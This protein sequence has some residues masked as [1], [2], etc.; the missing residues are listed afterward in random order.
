MAAGDLAAFQ[1]AILG[2]YDAHGRHLAFRGTRD[3]YAVLVSEAMAQQ[4]QISRVEPAWRAFM[5]RFP[6]VEALA[7][8]STAEVLR[9][10]T[11]L[12]YNRRAVNL[13][14]A[15]REAVASYGGQLPGDVAA[16]LAL[17]GVG[18]YTARAVA[19]IAFDLPVGA[20]DTN[21]RRVLGR[22]SAGAGAAP[23]PAE[24]QVLADASVPADRPADWTHAVMDVG[25]RFC[26]P[27]PAC[28]ACP[29]RPWCRYAA[30]A[31]TSAATG[32]AAGADTAGGAGSATAT[33]SAASAGLAAAPATRRRAARGARVPATPFAATS[34]WLRGRI[35]DRLRAVDG[36]DWLA[37]DGPIGDHG[38][39]TV[40]A[41]VARLAS[42]G[43]VELHGSN[44]ALARLPR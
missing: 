14:R 42:E 41:A 36:D 11:G 16:L 8:A 13:Q 2:W 37:L 39:D 38:A 31:G 12:G 28:D 25:A 3:P 1:A 30:D 15:A 26:R 27:R 18:P 7:A 9:A 10:W 5:A 44:P 19:S 20:V 34:R 6:T 32:R 40:A 33:G 23:G 21:V 4:T 29:A 17:P 22:V 43:L 24:L 35:I